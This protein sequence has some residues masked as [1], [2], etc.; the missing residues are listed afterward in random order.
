[1]RKRSLGVDGEAADSGF[2]VLFLSF[3]P[4]LCGYLMAWKRMQGRSKRCLVRNPKNPYSKCEMRP[5]PAEA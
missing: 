4:E 1:M 5:H 3:G 2:S